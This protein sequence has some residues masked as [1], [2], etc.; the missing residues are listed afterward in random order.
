MVTQRRYIRNFFSMS[1]YKITDALALVSIKCLSF[2][3]YLLSMYLF[4]ISP[5]YS[6]NWVEVEVGDDSGDTYL[7]PYFYSASRFVDGAS[8][9]KSTDGITY[10]EL[11]NAKKA[12][13]PNV[14]SLVVSKKANVM[15]KKLFGKIFTYISRQWGW[16]N[17]L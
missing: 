8:I 7:W 12:I 13:S 14:T 4:L 9:R 3:C 11:V 2:I 16:V 5:A 17:Q 1:G 10:V 6:A 15:E